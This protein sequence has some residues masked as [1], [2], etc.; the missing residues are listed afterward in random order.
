MIGPWEQ[1]TPELNFFLQ[2]FVMVEQVRG[3]D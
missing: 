1:M 3:M 2:I